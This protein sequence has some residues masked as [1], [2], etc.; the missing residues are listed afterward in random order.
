MKDQYTKELIF[1][2]VLYDKINL[3]KNNAEFL[4]K[5]QWQ[6]TKIPIYDLYTP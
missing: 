5:Q 1:E 4:H 2:L 6:N 3:R